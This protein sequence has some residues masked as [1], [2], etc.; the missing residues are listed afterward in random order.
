MRQAQFDI[1]QL[2][3]AGGGLELAAGF[4][5]QRDQLLFGERRRTKTDGFAF[6]EPIL[7]GGIVSGA[8]QLRAKLFVGAVEITPG[9]FGL[10]HM[11]I[12]IDDHDKL[13]T[14]D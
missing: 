4:F 13:L 9:L 8:E 1:A 11:G 3:R 7:H 12:G 6:A 5:G 2:A 14:T 10:H